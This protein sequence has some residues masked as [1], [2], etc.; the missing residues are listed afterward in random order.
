MPSPSQ[1]KKVFEQ[2]IAIDSKEERAAGVFILA[3]TVE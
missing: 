2:A 3:I 1:Q